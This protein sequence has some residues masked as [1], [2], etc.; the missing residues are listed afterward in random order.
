MNVESQYIEADLL[1]GKRN[2]TI[3]TAITIHNCTMKCCEVCCK[4]LKIRKN[5]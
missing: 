2:I 5:S 3:L 4:A 1:N